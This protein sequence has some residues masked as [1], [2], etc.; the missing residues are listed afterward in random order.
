M[1]RTKFSACVG[2]PLLFVAGALAAF[3]LSACSDDGPASPVSTSLMR[4]LSNAQA[5]E[6]QLYLLGATEYNGDITLEWRDFGVELTPGAFYDST[7]VFSADTTLSTQY[8]YR[9]KEIHLEFDP[10]TGD[11]VVLN[12]SLRFGNPSAGGSWDAAAHNIPLVSHETVDGHLEMVWRLDGVMVCA[13]IDS[14]N[15][16]GSRSMGE[17]VTWSCAGEEEA[18]IEVRVSN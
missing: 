17:L 9:H 7:S 15:Y 1:P 18:Y 16:R 6:V 11:I 13:A 5:A 3:L 4:D 14:L 10:H 2:L 8:S 12:S